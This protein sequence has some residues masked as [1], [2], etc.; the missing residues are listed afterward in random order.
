MSSYP[1]EPELL[2]V[3]DACTSISS[4]KINAVAKVAIKHIKFYKFVVHSVEKHLR[5]FNSGPLPLFV[6]GTVRSV[7]HARRTMCTGRMHAHTSFAPF[8]AL[9]NALAFVR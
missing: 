8:L 2:E 9:R 5:K 3:L 1:Q 7:G 4:T 6:I